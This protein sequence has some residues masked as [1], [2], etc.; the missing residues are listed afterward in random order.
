MTPLYEPDNAET[1]SDDETIPEIP[2]FTGV[3]QEQKNIGHLSQSELT[4]MDELFRHGS[5]IPS[6]EFIA[7]RPDPDDSRRIILEKIR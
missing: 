5:P 4:E 2:V 1:N 3:P 6:T 7:L